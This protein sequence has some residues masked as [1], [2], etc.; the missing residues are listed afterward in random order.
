M[1]GGPRLARR[2]AWTL[3]VLAPLASAAD[4]EIP[5]THREAVRAAAERGAALSRHDDAAARATD[6]M[7]KRRILKKDTRL[8]GWLT[9]PIDGDAQGVLVTFVGDVDGQPVA[10]YRLPVSGESVR[11][12]K[13]D[14]PQPL[15]ASQQA[16]WLARQAALQA[17]GLRD[18][19][20][21]ESYNPVVLPAGTGSDHLFVYLLAASTKPG[22]IVAGGH[23]RYEYSA[24]GTTAVANRA[25]TKACL[26][27]PPP[28][29][30]RDEQPIFMLSHLLDPTPTEIHVWLS[31]S[32]HRAGF[33]GTQEY[34]WAVDGANIQIV[35]RR[36][37]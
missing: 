1:S 35:D 23:F 9:D 12:E 25:F 18:D 10:L 19:V 33:I 22:E 7:A 13:L 11:L 3:L 15:S 6:L 20:C 34:V 4:I 24:D 8:R 5:E 17:L 14:S 16:R 29:R 36:S 31:L 2:A 37:P 26:T 32:Q 21:S 27:V 30:T 28:P